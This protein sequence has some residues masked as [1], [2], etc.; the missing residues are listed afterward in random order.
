MDNQIWKTSIALSI[1]VQLYTDMTIQ[2][3]QA[4]SSPLSVANSNA[5][6]KNEPES[7]ARVNPGLNK[8]RYRPNF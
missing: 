2:S 3:K 8:Q 4:D 7:S 5:S 1:L 6:A